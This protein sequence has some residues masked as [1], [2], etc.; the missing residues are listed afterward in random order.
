[1]TSADAQEPEGAFLVPFVDADDSRWVT[2]T[3]LSR[4]QLAREEGVTPGATPSPGAPEDQLATG[5]AARLAAVTAQYLRCV[6]RYHEDRRDDIAQAV[7]A[8]RQPRRA[9]LEAHRGTKN[10]WLVTREHLA[11]FLERRRPPAVRVAYDLTLTTEKSLG[12]LA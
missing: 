5:D 1:L 4:C 10:R 3:E 2:E 7:T 9:Y 6:A 11:E 12:V 8:G